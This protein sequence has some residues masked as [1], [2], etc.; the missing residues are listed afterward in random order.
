MYRV[1]SYP[2]VA[3]FPA[4][5]S[6]VIT[7]CSDVQVCSQFSKTGSPVWVASERLEAFASVIVNSGNGICTCRPSA[8]EVTWAKGKIL[9]DKVGAVRE[10]LMCH[11]EV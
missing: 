5:D 7:E 4:D 1:K 9:Y 10:G 2:C 6:P 11:H 3:V 8:V